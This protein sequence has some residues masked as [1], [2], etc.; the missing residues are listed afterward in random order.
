MSFKLNCSLLTSIRVKYNRS[1]SIRSNNLEK[2]LL[3]AD[4]LYLQASFP[5]ICFDLKYCFGDITL[6]MFLRAPNHLTQLVF[7]LNS[8]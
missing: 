5:L 6:K 8:T 2:S 7:D 4:S 3:N 1:Y